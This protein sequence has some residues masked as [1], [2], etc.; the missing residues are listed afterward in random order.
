MF[1]TSFIS[2]YRNSFPFILHPAIVQ[3]NVQSIN[4]LP[5]HT[6]NSDQRAMQQ[7]LFTI[8][9]FFEEALVHSRRSKH[10]PSLFLDFFDNKSYQIF[11]FR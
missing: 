7:E 3:Y 5:F 9:N 1:L 8:T 11:F 6:M 2:R 4:I 10:F